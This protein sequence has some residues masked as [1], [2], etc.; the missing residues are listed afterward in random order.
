MND[1]M[2]DGERVKTS[3]EELM[4]DG[5]TFTLSTLE[6]CGIT[7]EEMGLYSCSAQLESGLTVESEDFWVNVTLLGR[8]SA[9]LKNF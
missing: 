4:V 9:I 6:I 8:E 3:Q 7:S 2:G 1:S 5:T